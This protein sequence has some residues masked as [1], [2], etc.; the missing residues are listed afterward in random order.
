[1]ITDLIQFHDHLPL[2]VR[3]LFDFMFEIIIVRGILAPKIVSDI[4]QQHLTRINIIHDMVYV[5][6]KFMPDKA[7][8]QA[9]TEHWQMHVLGDGHEADSAGECLDGKCSSLA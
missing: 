2:L 4:K 9:I 3:W 5:I 7:S 8:R 6:N 1:M